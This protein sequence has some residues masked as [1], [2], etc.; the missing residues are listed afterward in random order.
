MIDSLTLKHAVTLNFKQANKNYLSKFT[1]ELSKVIN[2]SKAKILKIKLII[3]ISQDY[4]HFIHFL[5]KNSFGYNTK[6]FE[7]E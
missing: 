1:Q 4:N 3:V 5:N 7:K 2:M 6:N